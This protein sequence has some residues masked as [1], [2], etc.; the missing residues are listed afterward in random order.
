MAAGQDRQS[1]W[2]I[3]TEDKEF[4]RDITH[5]AVLWGFTVAQP[6][7]DLISQHGEF[8]VAHRVGPRHLIFLT[9]GLSLA[10][11]CFWLPCYG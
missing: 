3:Y 1:G 11:P 4:W 10:A 5:L 8:L 2:S 6:L 9:V 7:F